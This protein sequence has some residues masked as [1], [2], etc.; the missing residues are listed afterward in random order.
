MQMVVR[1]V[2]KIRKIWR[3]DELVMP[4]N[5]RDIIKKSQLH[6]NDTNINK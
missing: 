6:F 2:L 5:M 1:H 4:P 3:V